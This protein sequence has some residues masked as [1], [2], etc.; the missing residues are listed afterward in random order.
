MLVKNVFFQLGDLSGI[1]IPFDIYAIKTIA[2]VLELL[3]I[4]E[5]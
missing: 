5:K 3:Y 2:S 4:V 1:L